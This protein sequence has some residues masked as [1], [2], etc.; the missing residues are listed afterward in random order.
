[1]PT[2]KERDGEEGG[3]GKGREEEG[4]GERR[5]EGRGEPGP[6]YF[7]LEPPLYDDAA[8]TCIRGFMSPPPILWAALCFRPVRLFVRACVHARR[9]HSP[10]GFR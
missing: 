10:T 9:R 6:K 4:E 7:L 2:Y 3:E 5:K 1:M 8:V